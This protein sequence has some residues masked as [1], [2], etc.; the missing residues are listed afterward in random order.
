MRERKTC[1]CVSFILSLRFRIGRSPK[2]IDATE[3]TKTTVWEIANDDR[4]REIALE[5]Y[6]LVLNIITSRETE[7]QRGERKMKEA[8]TGLEPS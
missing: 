3:E 6:C 2:G 4:F 8:S 5:E 7:R 1:G